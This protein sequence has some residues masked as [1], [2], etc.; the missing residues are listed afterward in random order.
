MKSSK[1]LNESGNIQQ[2]QKSIIAGKLLI[3]ILFIFV[4]SWVSLMSSCMVAVRTPQYE[5][6]GVVIEHHERSH[7]YERGERR[8]HGGRHGHGER[9]DQGER[10]E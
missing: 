5:S 4:I 8:E 7:R 3:S 2:I 1:I 6:G 10:H 9:N